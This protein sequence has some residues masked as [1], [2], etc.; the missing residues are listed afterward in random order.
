MRPELRANVGKSTG[1]GTARRKGQGHEQLLWVAGV[2]FWAGAEWR[3]WAWGALTLLLPLQGDGG[4]PLVCKGLAHGV[5]SWSRGPCGR[6][7]DFFARV[8]LFRNW[9]DSVINQPA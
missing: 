9:I 5:A 7:T 1:R 4:T 6:G 2:V 8:A 3:F